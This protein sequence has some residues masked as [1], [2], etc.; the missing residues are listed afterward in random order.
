V[1]LLPDGGSP[2][3]PSTDGL[4][5]PSAPSAPPVPADRAGRLVGTLLTAVFLLL[6]LGAVGVF[7]PL[8]YVV[9]KPGPATDTLGTVDG[10]P[11]IRV[12]PG[13]RT[14]PT[15]GSLDFT[16]V[17]VLGGPGVQVNVYDVLLGWLSSSEAV[18]KDSEVFPPQS[19]EKEVQQ[20][21]Q[22][23]MTDSQ[24][25]AAATA[26]TAL[27]TTVPEHVTVA[28]VPEGSPAAGK[29]EAGDQLLSIG[30]TPVTDSASVRAAVQAHKPGESLA[31]QVRRKG[32]TST[33]TT[34]TAAGSDGSTI[35][36]IL[37][38]IAYD[39]PV[40]IAIDA[41][42]VGGPSAGM[43]FTL[44]I[45]DVLSPGALTGGRKIAGTGT[46]EPGGGVGPIDGIA[47][48]MVGAR[49]AGATWFLAPEANCPETVGH[50]PDGMHVLKVTDFDSALAAVKGI[51]AGSTASL[52]VCAAG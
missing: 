47:Q 2:N 17:R 19:T 31:V 6:A 38:G 40:D 46:I 41:G 51:A 7:V 32:T 23:M 35:I 9:F 8:P 48:K 52:P 33:V 11:V 4:P 39:L 13:T 27:G 5:A 28:A 22:I 50:V 26:L 42:G 1:T 14:Y 49:D 36:G 3:D 29:L 37:L 15:T 21:N 24:Q 20:E 12:P 34:S 44:G 30:G 45:Y 25:V 10:K 43:M 18:Y 16:T